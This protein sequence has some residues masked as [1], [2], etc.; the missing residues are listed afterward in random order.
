MTLCMYHSSALSFHPLLEGKMNLKLP[1]LREHQCLRAS[2]SQRSGTKEV[3][4]LYFT[5]IKSIII[6]VS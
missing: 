5:T 4:Y 6:P 3:A 1:E 2:K